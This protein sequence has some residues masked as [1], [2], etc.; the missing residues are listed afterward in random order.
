MRFASQIHGEW[1]LRALDVPFTRWAVHIDVFAGLPRRTPT[2]LGRPGLVDQLVPARAWRGSDQI[3]YEVQ[4]Q[5]LQNAGA[6]RLVP[7]QAVYYATNNPFRAV[8]FELF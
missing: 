2:V 4:N 3:R 1:S 6:E 8:S 7:P 5:I